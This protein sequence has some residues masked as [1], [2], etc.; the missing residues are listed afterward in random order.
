MRT[1]TIG[2]W[3]P[4]LVLGLLLTLLATPGANAGPAVPVTAA[5]EDTQLVSVW[6]FSEERRNL[7]DTVVTFFRLV[8]GTWTQER[9]VDTDQDGRVQLFVPVGTYKV[10][11][12]PASPDHQTVFNGGATTLETAEHVVVGP[13]DHPDLNVGVPARTWVA[14]RLLDPSGASLD[15]REMTIQKLYP[16]GRWSGVY[17]V[18]TGPDG[19]YRFGVYGPGLYRVAQETNSQL[20]LDAHS[21]VVEIDRRGQVVTGLD[22]RAAAPG[23]S[24]TGVVRRADGTRFA[25]ADLD[26]VRVV[27]G[28]TVTEF[29]GSYA[30]TDAQ[31]RYRFDDLA[32]GTYR[33]VAS[34]SFDDFTSA[35]WPDAARFADG[36]D[37]TVS[38][39]AT[40]RLTDIELR[41]VPLGRARALDPPTITGKPVVGSV[42]RAD[43]GYWG[44]PVNGENLR[45]GY[46]WFVDGRLVPGATSR[47]YRP[48]SADVGKPVVVMVTGS[49]PWAQPGIAFS[50][51]TDPVRLLPVRTASRAAA[52]APLPPS[53]S[54]FGPG[55]INGQLVGSGGLPVSGAL[56]EA[57]RSEGRY[58]APETVS[59]VPTDAQGRYELVGL[60]PGAYQVRF[61]PTGTQPAF[62]MTTAPES[63]TIVVD[64][65]HSSHVVD[66]RLA[67]AASIRGRVTL[68]SGAPAPFAEVQ[69][70][71]TDIAGG[72]FWHEHRTDADGRYT[73]LVQPGT[74]RVKFAKP[75]Y[76]FATT[77]WPSANSVAE[78]ENV[79]VAPGQSVTGIDARLVPGARIQGTVRRER[80]LDPLRVEIAIYQQTSE[81][82]VETRI[83]TSKY[84]SDSFGRFDLAGLAPGT[85]RIGFE[86]FGSDHVP[87]FWNDASSLEGAQDIVVPEGAVVTGKD[88]LIADRYPAYP[89][90]V[91]NQTRPRIKGVARVGRTLRVTKGAWVPATVR[92]RY[93]WLADGDPLPGEVGRTLR[94]RRS[95]LGDRLRV[96]VVAAAKY[97]QP[98]T[99]RTRATRPVR[100]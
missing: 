38:S 3:A 45:F 2:R 17:D 77:H 5:E 32:P 97:W 76:D 14:G 21:E 39:G 92:L 69:Y 53:A 29:L 28:R 73:I 56:V 11:F 89:I 83:E 10:R 40:T 84:L 13:D 26:L 85:Y 79:V 68:P 18:Q 23:G 55:R 42:L 41:R 35:V 1:T 46:Q 70:Q 61:H 59:T 50:E 48:T 15:R 43:P 64:A 6:V 25:G 31:G 24:I 16:D 72:G 65:E 34:D 54:G 99:V 100:R 74:Y 94:V 62:P 60:P 95:L 88:A 36:A 98:E 30:Y 63:G 90:R 57:H 27:D 67:P 58:G 19:S 7:E 12:A 49:G 87:E 81:G 86:P 75:Y 78:G 8:D 93:Q 37:I 47:S 91:V 20:T 51:P 96:R 80:T 22:V 9:E 82:W 4:V 52:A 33:V 71:R 66:A 44:L